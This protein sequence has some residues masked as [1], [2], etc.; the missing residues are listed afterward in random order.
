MKVGSTAEFIVDRRV[1]YWRVE[2]WRADKGSSIYTKIKTERVDTTECTFR[3]RRPNK[4]Q[5]YTTVTSFD[6]YGNSSTT[7]TS[8]VSLER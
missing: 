2:L 5:Y 4:S 3:V 1:A 8:T 6:A 7:I